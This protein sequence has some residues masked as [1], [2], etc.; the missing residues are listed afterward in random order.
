MGLRIAALCGVAAGSLGLGL[1]VAQGGDDALQGGAVAELRDA[2]G[3]E[4]GKAR[5]VGSPH[6]PLR[7]TVDVSGLSPG[8]HG[9]HVHDSGQCVAPF[10]TAGGHQ[11]S[12]TQ[13]HGS[14]DGDMPSLLVGPDG[15]AS[16]RFDISGLT[17]ADLVDE[18]PGDGSAVIVHAGR[19][20]FANIATRYHSDT[21][22][23]PASGPDATTLATGDS[24]AR[25]ACG[26]V[27]R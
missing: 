19:D 13:T 17:L 22:G 18:A 10:T 3:K 4:I 11:H 15:T 21:V 27:N 2:A 1:A 5:F 8:F 26:V 7:V 20:N 24:G 9:F 23:A 12:G 6:G 14:H 25:F 16:A